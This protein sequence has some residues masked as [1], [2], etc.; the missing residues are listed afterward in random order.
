MNMPMLHTE[1]V[2]PDDLQTGDFIVFGHPEIEKGGEYTGRIVFRL[3]TFHSWNVS[4]FGDKVL[5]AQGAN[6]YAP[7]PI[8]PEHMG[9][10]Y[11]AAFRVTNGMGESVGLRE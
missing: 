7:K 9:W 3:M 1:L 5:L 8:A 6:G 2:T 11:V 4:K 10:R